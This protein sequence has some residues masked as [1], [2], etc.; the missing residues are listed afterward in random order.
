MDYSET[1]RAAAQERLK[2]FKEGI[3]EE[4]PEE[5]KGDFAAELQWES[6]QSHL[7]ELEGEIEKLDHLLKS[8]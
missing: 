7:K 5:L 2:Q 8:Q 4:F 6:W 3:P 1:L